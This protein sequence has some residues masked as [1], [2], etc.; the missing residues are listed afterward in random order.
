M[1]AR[2]QTSPATSPD[3]EWAPSTVAPESSMSS[4]SEEINSPAFCS[5]KAARVLGTVTAWA[6][7]IDAFRTWTMC[8]SAAA[9]CARPAAARHAA[10]AAPDPSVATRIFA[11]SA[12]AA[13]LARGARFLFSITLASFP[14]GA[15]EHRHLCRAQRI[16][17]DAPEHEAPGDG[18]SGRQPKPCGV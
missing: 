5:R 13:S 6:L 10:L 14:E 4:T 3:A 12:P 18:S 16:R 8:S 15:D 17:R 11:K 1:R 2:E 7:G 9:F